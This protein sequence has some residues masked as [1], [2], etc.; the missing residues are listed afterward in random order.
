MNGKE[1]FLTTN[2]NL[3]L[4]LEGGHDFHYVALTNYF[5]SDESERMSLWND[6]GLLNSVK[7]KFASSYSPQLLKENLANLRQLLIEVTD[8]C[9]LLCKYCGY[10]EF[11]ENYDNRKDK[12]QTFDNVRPLIDYLCQFWESQS[13]ISYENRISIGFYGGEPLLNFEL[14]QEVVSYLEALQLPSLKFIYNI[15]TNAILLGK[16]MDFLVEKDFHLLLSLDGNEM[17][18]SYRL[19]QNGNASFDIVVANALKLKKKHPSFFEK[20][21]AFNTVLH[22]RNSV[23]ES[24]TFI[25][26][27]FGKVPSIAELNTNGIADEKRK[28]F[29]AMFVDKFGSFEQATNCEPLQ[30]KLLLSP[31]DLQLNS[32]LDTF[33]KNIYRSYMDL[34]LQTD[35]CE[36]IPTGTCAPFSR[37]IFLTVNG[38]ILPC[39]RMGQ[40]I[41]LGY[42][43]NRQ[44]ELDLDKVIDF[45]RKKYE[46]LISK[47]TECVQWK[48]CG[49]CIYYMKEKGGRLVCPIFYP[50]RLAE[51][52]Y[53]S[54]FISML[55]E[56]PDAYKR[57]VNEVMI[58]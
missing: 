35:D 54:R 29:R 42:V 8:G 23:E 46:Q 26:N 19:T 39:E 15:T 14:I 11:Y 47:C 27:T 16:Y 51:R 45:Y 2:D 34:F 57:I 20:N 49:M 22:N 24:V 56:H 58:D 48:N 21:V 40:D 28:E 37:K 4:Y 13:N 30:E 36:Y 44:V 5:H 50:R 6:C 12:K 7:P 18:N 25:W 55:E 33:T 3:Y 41:A 17:N 38:K 10:G 1:K 43:R 9:N 32:F 53:F 31:N 52:E